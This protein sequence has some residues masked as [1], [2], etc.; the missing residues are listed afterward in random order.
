M[1][2]WEER[3]IESIRFEYREENDTQM[4]MIALQSTALFTERTILCIVFLPN[5][6]LQEHVL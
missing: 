2:A 5:T 3:E 6:F 4:M 1:Q